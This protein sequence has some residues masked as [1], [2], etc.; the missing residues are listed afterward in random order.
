LLGCCNHKTQVA[1]PQVHFWFSW[2][3]NYCIL[4]HSSRISFVLHFCNY[5]AHRE[6]QHQQVDTSEMIYCCS[7]PAN[8]ITTS[9]WSIFAEFFFWRICGDLVY[10][11]VILGFR[12]KLL[13]AISRLW[14]FVCS[15]VSMC[16]YIDVHSLCFSFQKCL[17]LLV[18]IWK[19]QCWKTILQ[20]ENY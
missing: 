15:F 11:C 10:T 7:F 5:C 6:H 14:V 8:L 18:H 19:C 20:N 9:A 17:H 2:Y 1:L 4:N 12:E 16:R 13:G 3:K